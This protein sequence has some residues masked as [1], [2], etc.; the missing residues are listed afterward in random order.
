MEVHDVE[1]V[2]S[3]VDPKQY[4]TTGDPEIALVGRSN[5]GKSSLTNVLINRNSYAHT[6]SQPGKTQT[7]NFYHVES[8]MY[9]VDVPGYGYAKASRTDREKWGQMIETYLTQRE[10]LRGVVSLVDGRHEPTKDDQQMYTWLAYYDIPTLVV[11]TKL[12]KISRG[13][14]NK[15]LSM[16]KKTLQLKPEDALLPFSA[17]TKMGKDAVWDWIETQAFGGKLG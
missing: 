16:I 15:Q 7:L 3:A 11:A 4:P 14:W 2:M 13:K 5:V 12:D 1:L 6:S 9:F 17:Q 8:Q 10:Q